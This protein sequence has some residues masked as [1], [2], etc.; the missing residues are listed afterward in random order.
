MSSTRKS[1]QDAVRRRQ[2]A[3]FV[4]RMAELAQFKVNLALSAD[5]PDRRF[6]FSVHGDGGVGKSFLLRQWGGITRAAGAVACWIDEPVFGVPEAMRAIAVDLAR[7]GIET[8]GFLTLLDGYQQRRFEAEADPDA[9]SGLAAFMTQTAV[10]IGLHAAHAVPGVGGLADSVDAN[11]LVAQADQLRVFLGKKFRRHEDVRLL[12]SPLDMLTPVLVRDLARA[13][14]RRTLALFFDTYE[15]TGLVLDGWLRSALDGAYGDLPEDMVIAIAGRRPLAVSGWA[16]YLGIIAD[17]PLEPFTTTE[18]RQFLAERGINDDRVVKVILSVSGRL[19]LL[20]ATLAENQPGDPDLVGDPSG[21]AVERFL[22]WELD[23]ARRALAVAAALPRV[24]NEDVLAVLLADG[25]GLE[26][27]RLFAWLRSLPFITDNAGRCQYHDVVRAAM[28]RLERRQSP[29]RWK[30]RHR[31]LAAAYVAWQLDHCQEDAWNDSAWRGLRLEQ[32]YHQLCAAPATALA[33]ALSEIVRA[34]AGQ[35]AAAAQWAQAITQAGYDT[36]VDDLRTV[37]QQL[38]EVIRQNPEEPTV[39]CLGVILRQDELPADSV[40]LALHVK[41]RALYHLDRE[42][43]AL[44]DLDQALALTPD[45][46]A[47]LGDRGETYRWLGRYEEA[48]ADLDRAVELDPGLQS[49]VACRGAT[50]RQMGRYSDALADLDRAIDLD[51]A[52]AWALAN[53]GETYRQMDRYSDAL[54]DLD[55]AIDLDPAYQWALAS[56]GET[57]RQMG[58]YSDALADLD[59]AIDLDPADAWALANRGET[60][61]RTGR[62]SDALADLDRA[63]DLDPAY[64]WALA[65]RGETYRQMSRYSDALA[66][67]DRAIDLDRS[68]DWAVGIRGETYR[69][70]GR[71]SDALADLDRAIDLEPKNDWY[72]YLRSLVRPEPWAGSKS[73]DKL[74]TA[75]NA[76]QQ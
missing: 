9:P 63:I 28:I 21:D 60:H 12:L 48:L 31:A 52:D 42:S 39:A 29:A 36:G 10:R 59:R 26:R 11:A 4:G 22:K 6:I 15:Q 50:R 69:Q 76:K 17:V 47:C 33:E 66:D 54:A 18:A 2:Q 46:A 14:Q 64:Q 13:G 53:R 20:L 75:V 16:S 74:E 65:S 40:P 62:Y 43:E 38:E 24:I 44:A 35:P 5:D 1:F 61:R 41:G 37:G 55:R 72:H 68:D 51:P 71:Y 58:R 23:P 27:G 25:D 19:P 32:T 49:A 73:T 57:Y 34:C 67:L 56:R 70:M 30:E 45:Y 8:D 7:Q 3:G